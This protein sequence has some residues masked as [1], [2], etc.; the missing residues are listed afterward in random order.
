MASEV[1]VA[2]TVVENGPLSAKS[3]IPTLW[4]LGIATAGGLINFYGKYRSG[5][6]RAFNLTELIG[7][8]VI[9]AAVGLLTFWICR[10]FA[11]NEWLTAA[12]VAISGHMG[13]RAI[14][15]LEN[16][17]AKKADTWAAR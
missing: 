9:S 6:V 3:L 12:G 7:E 2:K 17:L 1:E 14:M 13:A 4:M 11:V 5:K 15:L 8:I 16:A 10:G